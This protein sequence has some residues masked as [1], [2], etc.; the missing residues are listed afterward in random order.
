MTAIPDGKNHN[1]I[2]I[3]VLMLIL[4]ITYAL[5]SRSD[6]SLHVQPPS[7]ELILIF[8]VTYLFGT[9]FLSPDLDIESSPYNRWGVFKF[10]WWPYKVIFK[11]RG[12]SHHPIFGPLTILFNFALIF[13][14][15]LVVLGF[16]RTLFSLDVSVV[17]ATGF[18]LSIEM[19]ILADVMAS[20]LT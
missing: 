9:F 3:I 1:K 5:F 6:I 12:L 19:H 17:A 14:P 11:H 20:N 4:S 18:V 10:L 13:V 15:I 16:N 7:I 2:N 8:S